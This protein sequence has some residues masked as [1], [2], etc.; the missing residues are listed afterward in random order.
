MSRTKIRTVHI[1]QLSALKKLTIQDLVVFY[2]ASE[3][4]LDG[5]QGIMNQP[6]AG[7]GADGLIE[8]LLTEHCGLLMGAAIKELQGRKPKDERDLEL[9]NAC[10]ASHQIFSGE[11]TAAVKTLLDIGIRPA[12]AKAAA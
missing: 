6:R 5:A 3:D 9:R 7:G 12:V 8:E 4:A 10:L 1:D 2:D 11:Y